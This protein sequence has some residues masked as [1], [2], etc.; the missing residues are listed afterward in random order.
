MFAENA[1]YRPS[2]YPG[3]GRDL[4][5]GFD[6]IIAYLDRM[7]AE[8]IEIFFTL[9]PEGL[10]ARCVTSGG[11]AIPV[12]KWLRSMI[13]HEIHHRGQIYVY[14]GMLDVPTPPLYGLTEGEVKARSAGGR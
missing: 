1:R 8:T 4:A 14:S 9:S 13:E 5:E 11:A 12:W 3:H 2:R 10:A 6:A 7:H